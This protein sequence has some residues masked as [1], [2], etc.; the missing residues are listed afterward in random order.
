MRARRVRWLRRG[1]SRT[2]RPVLAIA[3]AGLLVPLTAT[4]AA[5]AATANP[6]TL[7]LTP[8]RAT[9]GDSA[10]VFVFNYTAPAKP[11]PG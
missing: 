1:T 8:G 9:A 10:D 2:A 5:Q 11:V 4:G 3:V 6:G 7:K